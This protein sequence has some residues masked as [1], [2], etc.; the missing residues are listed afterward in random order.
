LPEQAT[1]AQ[2]LLAELSHANAG[3]Q[4]M[5]DYAKLESA[6]VDGG[7]RNCTAA[8]API[9]NAACE[10][11]RGEATFMIGNSPAMREVFEQIRRY[12]TCDATV[13]IHGESG[14]GKKLVARAMHER[15]SRAKSPFL[16]VNCTALPATLIAA[17]LF[18]YEKGAFTGATAR[19]RGVIEA[20]NNGT[21][22]LDGIG[23]MPI[24]LQG[25]L[26]R[27]LQENEIVRLGGHE[28]IPL[29]V[30]VI[31]A[32]NMR[33]RDAVGAGQLRE[34]LYYRLNVLSMDLPSLRERGDDVEI[35]AQYFLQRFSKELGRELRGF[36]PAAHA[37]IKNYSW[38][39]NVRELIATIRRAAVM[40]ND[41]LVDVNDLKLEVSRP[42][43][44]YLKSYGDNRPSPGTG[45]ERALLL[46]VLQESH[47]NITRSARA[48]QVSRVTFYRMLSRNHMSLR[49]QYVIQEPSI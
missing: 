38:P 34:D 14:T 4:I 3:G 17:E 45:E 19:K 9:A 16:A 27:F 11:E 1:D 20:A 48:L 29:D 22:F 24:D 21:L 5:A 12:A 31:A 8:I 30:R 49:Q 44:R 32:A 2:R 15:S 40:S 43:V 41:L 6:P 46:R 35:F 18:G 39:G 13:L 23:D 37:A 28:P 42:I 26:L 36:T 7:E 33:L 47:Y 10:T 25:H